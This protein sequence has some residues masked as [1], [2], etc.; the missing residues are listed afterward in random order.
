MEHNNL[1]EVSKGWLYGLS[2]LQRLHLAHNA[3]SRIKADPWEPCQKLAEL[4]VSLLSF[5]LLIFFLTLQQGLKPLEKGQGSSKGQQ[6]FLAL[7]IKW[8]RF[9]PKKP[10]Y[11]KNILLI[12]F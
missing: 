8:V 4:Y 12:K 1:T 11:F 7:G 6:Y 2:S 3:I 9:S 10:H 5:S